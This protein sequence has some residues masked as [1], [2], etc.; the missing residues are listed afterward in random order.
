MKMLRACSLALVLMLDPAF[1]QDGQ[2]DT[3]G[4][5][6]LG[7][8]ANALALDNERVPFVPT[9]SPGHSSKLLNGIIGYQFNERW[10]ADITLGTDVGGEAETDYVLINGYRFFTNKKWKPFVSAGLSS[11]SI[12]D[13]TDDST[14]QLQAGVGISGALTERL[15]LRVGY[16]LFTELGGDSNFDKA[17]GLALNW[18]LGGP[19]GAGGANPAGTG[20][21][22]GA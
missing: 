4:H 1:G 9:S 3:G 17:F 13:A 5:V 7:L 15:E 2:D 22:S 16:Q 6:Y 21:R 20:P 18:H 19:C 14:Q 12:D 8:G 11:F 10:A